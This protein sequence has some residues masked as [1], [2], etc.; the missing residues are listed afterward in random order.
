M[1]VHREIEVKLGAPEHG[2]LPDLT[3]L[4][5]V[6]AV[7]PPVVAEL[8]A[9]YL[10][11]VDRRLATAGITLR[12]RTG[13]ADEGWHLKLRVGADE[14][15]EIHAAW[16]ET[17]VPD[18]L[19]ASLRSRLRGAAV[20]P[21]ARVS[22]RRTLHRLRDAAGQVIAEVVDDEVSAQDLT[23]PA[24]AEA[25]Q[26]WREWEIEL[27]AGDRALLAQARGSLRAAGGTVPWW[28]SKVLRAL[29]VESPDAARH[30]R[31]RVAA[32]T[33]LRQFLRAARDELASW[34]VQVR[35]SEPDAV[36]QMRV[37]LR[38]LRSAL[39]TFRDVLDDEPS[40]WVREEL[41]WLGGVLGAARDAEVVRDLAIDLVAAEPPGL[42]RGAVAARL[43]AD[44]AAA[45]GAAMADVTRAL[46]SERYRVLLDAL[47]R[48]VVDP[49]FTAVAAEPAADVLPRRVRRE[50][51]RLDRAVGA[52]ATASPGESRDRALH[53]A[54]KA[55]KR[56][57]YSAETL[58]PV[59]GRAAVRSARAAQELQTLLGDHHDT[60]TVRET[61][62][63]AALE[64]ARAG[65]DTFTYGR[66][67]ALAQS[68]AEMLERQLPEVVE[69][70]RSGRHRRWMR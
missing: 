17:E 25:L 1:A 3:E 10:D 51:A 68:R 65:E 34:D 42:L 30:G 14:R 52:V 37:T 69:R 24:G 50:W 43:G 61:L 62:E 55:A 31:R 41:G 9:V 26:T 19:V 58:A 13:G 18:D 20:V 29:G 15:A 5:G 6:T 57:R 48:L 33:V 60:V 63:R 39:G 11:T 22:T 7:D 4:D 28:S 12:R 56:A 23:A 21:V 32:A 44:R 8:D 49:P 70:L 38:E 53:E 59:V 36:H 45:H 47:D 35:R 40:A 54:R 67:H 46:D 66:L 64:A 16:S 27:V 2:A